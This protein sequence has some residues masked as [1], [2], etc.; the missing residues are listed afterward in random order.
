LNERRF[1]DIKNIQENVTDLWVL[2]RKRSY[3][4][5]SNSRS[6]AGLNV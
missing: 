1:Q 3:R 6:I 2:L 4:N 5:V